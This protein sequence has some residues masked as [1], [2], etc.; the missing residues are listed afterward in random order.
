MPDDGVRK[1]DHVSPVFKE[2]E[3]QRVENQCFYDM[4]ILVFKI[5][6]SQLPDWLFNMFTL[7]EITCTNTRQWNNLF[8]PRTNKATGTKMLS[9]GGPLLWNEIPSEIR[10][11]RSI[12]SF[13]N[14][15][16]KYLLC[17]QN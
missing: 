5:L 2:L 9:V 16:K 14:K 4:C 13:K 15:L 6:D 12:F 11:T 7:R 17:K 8:V 1:Y 3:C 10:D